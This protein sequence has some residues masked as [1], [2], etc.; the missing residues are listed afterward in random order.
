MKDF[1]SEFYSYLQHH[2]HID[3]EAQYEY[4]KVYVQ[5][6]GPGESVLDVGCGRGEFLELLRDKGCVASGVDIDIGMVEVC[7]RKGLDVYHDDAFQFLEKQE[8]TYDGIFAANFVEHLTPAQVSDFL[9]KAY[10]ALK[11]NGRLVIAVPNP[12]SIAVHLYEFWRD[13]THVRMYSKSLLE[14]MLAYAGFEVVESGENEATKCSPEID[15]QRLR[16]VTRIEVVPPKVQEAEHLVPLDILPPIVRSE[17]LE[18]NWTPGSIRCMIFPPKRPRVRGVLARIRR[19]IADFLSRHIL[20]E[21]FSAIQRGFDQLDRRVGESL[22]RVSH[23][24]ERVNWAL[25]LVNQN[26]DR[27]NQGFERA[28]Q[29]FSRANWAF[30]RVARNA[31]LLNQALDEVNRNTDRMGYNLK[32]LRDSFLSLYAAREIYVVG[33]KPEVNP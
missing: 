20:F 27:V 23:N 24:F 25:D 13:A 8:A 15:M 16:H 12:E 33:K 2:G 32:N 29:N 4:F 6:F 31:E 7:H 19:L 26:F 5:Y 11:S 14:F 18:L 17:F 28:N 3:E 9:K 10:K 1:E 22:E 30:R 21:E